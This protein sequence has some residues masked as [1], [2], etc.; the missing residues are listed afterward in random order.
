MKN[1]QYL[2]VFLLIVVI[3]MQG[4]YIYNSQKQNSVV[5]KS[6]QKVVPAEQLAQA[7]VKDEDLDKVFRGNP[8]EQ[9][10]KMEQ[11]MQKIFNSM[12]SQFASM[13]E[14]EKFFRD[15]MSISP[16]LDFKRHKDRYELRVS[17]PGSDKNS[18]KITTKDGVLNIEAKT[19][20]KKDEKNSG[21]IKKEIY[22]GS[23]IRS[24][25][26]P[27]DVDVEKMKTEYKNGVLK[28]TLP[29]K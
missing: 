24:L 13:P 16:A 7:L 25:S 22:E 29:K 17:I 20:V 21:F 4:Y 3:G 19:K 10:Q 14:F 8:F 5:T 6:T 23:F 11:N 9:M 28:I 15:D 2:I 18:I 1:I 26:L 27:S 12:N